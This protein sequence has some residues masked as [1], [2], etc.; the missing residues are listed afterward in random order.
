M[1]VCVCVCLRLYA[2]LCVSA[3]D[4]FSNHLLLPPPLAPLADKFDSQLAV[5]D[6]SNRN[7]KDDFYDI[8]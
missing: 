2:P 3:V 8:I 1:C 7:T 5:Q 4:L 6:N